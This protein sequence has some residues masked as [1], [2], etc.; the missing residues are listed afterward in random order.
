MSRINFSARHEYESLS[1]YKVLQN[2]MIK[3]RIEKPVPVDR[4]VRSKMQDNLEFLQ[5][6]KKFWDTHYTGEG[7]YNAEARRAGHPG[8]PSSSMDRHTPASFSARP[9]PSAA[10]ARPSAAGARAAPRP[11]MA[12]GRVS[13]AAGP[14]A[15]S[16]ARNPSTHGA[17]RRMSVAPPQRG[18][19]PPVP[20]ETI[21]QLT[22]EIDD[23]KVSVDSLERER[24]FYFGKLRD[25]EVLVQER[26]AALVPAD[27]AAPADAANAAEVD[28]LKQIQGVLYQTEEGFELPDAMEVRCRAD[29]ARGRTAARRGRDVLAWLAWGCRTTPSAEVHRSPGAPPRR[30]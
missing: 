9:R 20:N 6:L 11:S 30:P 5:W 1:N 21:Q 7:T 19:A 14:R 18:Y 12:S 29:A 27:D 26:L 13:G 24:D 16:S 23:M 10:G 8:A 25:V 17:A 2:V 28:T 22:A 15:P 3:N 4:L